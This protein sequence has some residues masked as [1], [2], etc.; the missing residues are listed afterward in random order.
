M[1]VLAFHLDGHCSA[2]YLKMDWGGVLI[3]YGSR[4]GDVLEDVKTMEDADRFFQE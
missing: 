4:P 3:G 1:L 2:E